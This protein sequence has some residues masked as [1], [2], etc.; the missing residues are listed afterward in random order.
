MEISIL[1]YGANSVTLLWLHIALYYYQLLE[2][3]D[4]W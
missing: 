2:D 3:S 4:I 1:D